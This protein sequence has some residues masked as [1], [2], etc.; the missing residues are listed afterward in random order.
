VTI[1]DVWTEVW[2]LRLDKK[3]ETL[4]TEPTCFVT[5]MGKRRNLYRHIGLIVWQGNTKKTDK[6]KDRRD[7]SCEDGS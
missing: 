2:K 3:K 1:V 4:C 5:G 6:V 7:I